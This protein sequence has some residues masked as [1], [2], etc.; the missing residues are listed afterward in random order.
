[1]VRSRSDD[2]NG[3]KEGNNGDRARAQLTGAQR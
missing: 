2:G 3:G 1:M